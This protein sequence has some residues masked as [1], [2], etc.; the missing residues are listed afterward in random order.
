MN[1][2]ICLLLL[3]ISSLPLTAYD[4][5]RHHHQQHQ[6]HYNYRRYNGRNTAIATGAIIGSGIVGY[7]IGR[8]QSSNNNRNRRDDS[9]DSTIQCRDFPVQATVDGERKV[10]LITKCRV[11]D[12]E[13]KFPEN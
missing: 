13:W 3:L 1:K 7:I 2:T 11:G 12:G 10:I 6:R 4:R 9:Y 8:G 5:Y